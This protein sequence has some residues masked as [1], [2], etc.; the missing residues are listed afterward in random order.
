MSFQPIIPS[1]GYGGW[2]F[3][4]RTM[5]SQK[6]VFT[7][8]PEIKRDIDHFKAEIGKVKTAR[9]LVNDPK[10]LRVA[11]GAFD[12]SGDMQN[13]FFI[14][15]I[16]TEGTSDPKALANRMGDKRYAAMAKAFGFGNLGGANTYRDSFVNDTIKRFAD[17]KFE[18]AVG[19]TAPDMRIALNLTQGLADA[20]K[21]STSDSAHWYRVMGT[22]PLRKAFETALGLPSSIGKLDIDQQLDQ[23]QRRARSV[24]GSEKVSEINTEENREKLSRLFLLRSEA[25]RFSAANNSLQTAS[26]LLSQIQ[27]PKFQG[28]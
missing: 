10:L 24:F 2:K 18:T 22:P 19:Q 26:M 17:K 5:A 11:L 14:E 6:E 3:L 25:N 13:K 20:T 28:F 21:G 15:R 4:Q 23:F 27:F 1:T 12:L 16:L 9:D 8:S 7:S